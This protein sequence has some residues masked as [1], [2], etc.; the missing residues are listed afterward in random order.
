[1]P[2][3]P[4][5][6]HP[7]DT[8]GLIAPASAPR[9]PAAVEQSIT[10]LEKLGFKVKLGRSAKKRWGFL[11]G[12]DRER[13]G[14]VMAMFANPKI[15]G[16]ICLRG[17]YGTSRLVSRLDFDVIRKN[18]KVFA[19]YSDI[20][21]LHCAFLKKS[22]LLT[23]HAP[24][25][26][27]EIIKKDFPG[28]SR[29]SFL[30]LLTKPEP[31]GSICHG[32]PDKTVSIIT[33]GTASGALIGGNLTIICSLIGT[34]FAPSFRG[35]ILFLED[36]EEAP[37]RIDRMLTHL[38]NAGILGQVAGVAVGICKDCEDANAKPGGEYRQTLADVFQDRL[39]PLG[40]PVV[41]G[42]PFGHVPFN[43]TIPVGGRATLDGNKGDLILTAAMVR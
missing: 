40:I 15:N 39:K 10:A 33:P 42:L 37:Y 31:A 5:R 18:P 43:A 35:K 25:P 16:I 14:D 21:F 6:L 19:G 36:L 34:P 38:L 28:F 8:L 11:A 29:D 30:G 1:M 17:G 23:F 27:S 22:G 13:A 9:D 12:Q 3:L 32:Y 41:S 24:M 7:G 26:A 20:T 4:H 2:T